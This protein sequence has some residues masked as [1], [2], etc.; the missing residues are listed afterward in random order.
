MKMGGTDVYVG[1]AAAGAVILGGVVATFYLAMPVAESPGGG[2][3]QQQQTRVGQGSV[4]HSTRLPAFFVAYVRC[5][6]RG[7]PH[8]EPTNHNRPTPTPPPSPRTATCPAARPTPQGLV[9][10][11]RCCPAPIYPCPGV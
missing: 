10:S 2:H 6:V 3:G 8:G 4:V 7:N 5:T 1:R 11:R 9:S